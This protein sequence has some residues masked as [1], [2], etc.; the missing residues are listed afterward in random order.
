MN[1]SV[2]VPDDLWNTAR[3]FDL[4]IPASRL[5]QEAIRLWIHNEWKQAIAD[6]EFEPSFSFT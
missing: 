1:M 5:V 4:D 3:A 2:F 6:L